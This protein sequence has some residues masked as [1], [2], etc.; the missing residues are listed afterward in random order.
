MISPLYSVRDIKTGSYDAPFPSTN[1]DTARR[2]FG[3]VIE[4]VPLMREHPQD[5]E[6]YQVGSFDNDSGKPISLEN[7]CDYVCSGLDCIK[8]NQEIKPDEKPQTTFGDDS[9]VQS[10]SQS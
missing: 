8:N 5:F 2:Y 9:P 4:Q 3:R 7:G 1:S 6:L 10:S